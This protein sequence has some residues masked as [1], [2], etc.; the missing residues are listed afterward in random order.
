MTRTIPLSAALLVVAYGGIVISA[1]PKPSVTNAPAQDAG[2]QPAPE[3]GAGSDA[4]PNDVATEPGDSGKNW[5]EMTGFWL[6]HAKAEPLVPILRQ[7]FN[8]A[9]ITADPERNGILMIG[10]RVD[11]S[12][13]WEVVKKFD[14]AH[15]GRPIRSSPIDGAPK[16]SVSGKLADELT[17][18]YLKH[19]K[20]QSVSAILSQLFRDFTPVVDHR[21]N[22]IIVRSD[23][24]E[25]LDKLEAVLKLLDQP[26]RPDQAKQPNQADRDRKPTPEDFMRALRG[27][28]GPSAPKKPPVVPRQLSP[29]D[30]LRALRGGAGTTAR[31]QPDTLR[32]KYNELEQQAAQT[33]EEYRDLPNK[34]TRAR[35]GAAALKKQ[36][37]ETVEQAFEARQELQRAELAA[38]RQRLVRIEGQIAARERIK[39]EI[40]DRR[41]EDLLNPEL[42]WDGAGESTSRPATSAR[43]SQSQA[44]QAMTQTGDHVPADS[45]ADAQIVFRGLE[46]AR[47]TCSRKGS[48]ASVI[49]LPGRLG[50]STGQTVPFRL[51]DIPAHAGLDLNGT[52]ELPPIGAQ[53]RTFLQHNA[54]PIEFHNED[55]DQASS[56]HLVT[57]VIYLP[58]P[59]HQ[60]L[61][62][63]G[64]ETIVS[65]RLDPGVNPTTEAERRGHILATLRLGNRVPDDPGSAIEA[66]RGPSWAGNMFSETLCEL[67]VVAPGAKVQHRFALENPYVEDARIASVRSANKCI[68]ATQVTKPL[69]KTHDKSEIVVQV[70]A[71]QTP[72]DHT[73][74]LTVV[75]DRPFDAE[76]DLRLKWSVR[77]LP[78]LEPVDEETRVDGAEM[79]DPAKLIW[80][81]LGVKL[82]SVSRDALPTKRFRGGMQVIEVRKDGAAAEAKLQVDDIIVGI[83]HWET[84]SVKN[85]AYVLKHSDLQPK[86]NQSSDV[87]CFVLRGDETLF[88]TLR[89]ADPSKAADQ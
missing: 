78:Q 31:Q 54:I 79:E 24:Q 86:Q 52:I 7:L 40:I 87:K 58:K 21:L 49:R 73:E 15:A 77:E 9:T 74:T 1:Q 38:L 14:Q 51:S 13:A 22:A 35:T 60:E 23:S 46:G 12:E 29:E 42:R 45:K 84:V 39:D 62:L 10:S 32:E 25:N 50:V 53:T 83:H 55:V 20:A 82:R 59:E 81:V 76:V 56:G 75:F 33:A 64:V 6:E 19:T 17:V 28:T 36:L 68:S 67:G 69:L 11:V 85:V 26:I 70:A 44:P 4:K 18:F 34:A 72:G 27:G 30:L 43:V 8:T 16:M 80:D 71:E 57:K 37:A 5:E 48:A 89:L 2:G 47:V 61:A 3:K 41:I 66:S 63:A 65:T 88:T